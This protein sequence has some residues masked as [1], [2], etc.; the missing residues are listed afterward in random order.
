MTSGLLVDLVAVESFG[1]HEEGEIREEG[2]VLLM[3][4]GT[5]VYPLKRAVR[6]AEKVE[7]EIPA[8][9]P[10]SLGGN[11]AARRPHTLTKKAEGTAVIA[12][13]KNSEDVSS[14]F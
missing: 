5:L 9:P 10:R 4:G 2:G 1:E 13:P 11:R 8:L 12:V 7:A 14:L 3:K 6:W